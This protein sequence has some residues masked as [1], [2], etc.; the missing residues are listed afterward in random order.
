MVSITLC[1]YEHSC[2]QKLALKRGLI[3]KN[4]FFVPLSHF[5]FMHIA[6]KKI[7]TRE[8]L[9]ER[10]PF[11]PINLFVSFRLP[12]VPYQPVS[13]KVLC[14]VSYPFSLFIFSLNSRFTDLMHLL[15]VQNVSVF[16]LVTSNNLL[17]CLSPF[18]LINLCPF[19]PDLSIGCSL[20]AGPQFVSV[21]RRSMVSF[22]RPTNLSYASND[23]LQWS[24]QCVS[25]W[26][27]AFSFK[28]SPF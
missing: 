9:V 13:L 5:I 8:S 25:Y 10:S 27:L 14:C 23:L 26:K 1:S 21:L 18:V 20:L 6:R 7:F 17:P 4:H 19:F 15:L 24:L 2:D 11:V 16:R 22:F 28:C 12:V 3:L